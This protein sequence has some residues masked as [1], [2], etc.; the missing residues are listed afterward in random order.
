M[1]V[2]WDSIAVHIGI[3]QAKAGRAPVIKCD[4]EQLL[5]GW[6]NFVAQ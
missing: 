5:T 3:K 4:Y 6:Y 1:T 2:T